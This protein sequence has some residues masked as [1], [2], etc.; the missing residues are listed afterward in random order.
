MV[1][2]HGTGKTYTFLRLQSQFKNEIEFFP[3]MP[4]QISLIAEKV[5]VNVLQDTILDYYYKC[6]HKFIDSKKL[7]AIFDQGPISSLSYYRWFMKSTN[8]T[9]KTFLRHLI[10]RVDECHD[11][12]NEI[13]DFCYMYFRLSVSDILTN[14]FKRFRTEPVRKTFNESD[15]SYIRFIKDNLKAESLKYKNYEVFSQDYSNIAK[16]V[17]GVLSNGTILTE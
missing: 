9:N 13:A 14:I 5:S 12:L 15:I 10:N 7:V 11:S 8:L 6:L 16:I 3:E 2:C 17:W 1:G 4:S